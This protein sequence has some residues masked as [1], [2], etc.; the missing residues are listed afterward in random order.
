MAEGRRSPPGNRTGEGPL[1]QHRRPTTDTPQQP[2]GPRITGVLPNRPTCVG[3]AASSDR[4]TWNGERPAPT[5]LKP[6]AQEAKAGLSS[7]T[8]PLPS[9]SPSKEHGSFHVERTARPIAQRGGRLLPRPES[10]LD[11][12][13]KQESNSCRSPKMRS[14]HV[15]REHPHRANPLSSQ[16][17]PE[18][19]VHNHQ[20]FPQ[21]GIRAARQPSPQ[22][23]YASTRKTR[24]RS[25][26]GCPAE[27]S[28]SRLHTTLR[29]RLRAETKREQTAPGGRGSFHV[30]RTTTEGPQCHHATAPGAQRREHLG[31]RSP[32][33][34]RPTLSLRPIP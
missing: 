15:E 17:E 33:Q 27:K 34:A 29:Y 32:D 21:T 28:A 4:S 1:Q 18:P 22:T 11:Y 2:K 25:Q 31:P 10:L 5:Q 7:H 14:F 19:R 30:E 9:S 24:P 16:W 26:P 12:A 6:T 13:A 23:A 8:A 3:R 20:K